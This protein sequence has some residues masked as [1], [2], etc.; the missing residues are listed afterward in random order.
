[1]PYR[2]LLTRDIKRQ[3]Q[4]LPGNIR[5]LARQQ[6]AGLASDPRP[7]RSKELQGHAGHYRLWLGAKH[8][9]VWQVI[10]EEKLVEIEYIGPKAPDLYKTLDLARPG[11]E[12]PKES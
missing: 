2:I 11:H 1:M 8:R 3:L 5:A 4:E 10:E 9:L 7:A 6:I 12:P